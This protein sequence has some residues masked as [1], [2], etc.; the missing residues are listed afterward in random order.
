MDRWVATSSRG[1]GERETKE[2]G[3]ER[4]REGE[5]ERGK[6]RGREFC[7]LHNKCRGGKHYSIES[8]LLNKTIFI[9]AM[10]SQ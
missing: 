6:E 1:G 5:R 3:K 9:C 4:G 2:R 8:S 10:L 7:N